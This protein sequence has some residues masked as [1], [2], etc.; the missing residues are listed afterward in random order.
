MKRLALTTASISVLLLVASTATGA[1]NARLQGAFQVTATV[2]KSDS[3]EPGTQVERTYKFKPL[4]DQGVCEKVRISRESSTG[5]FVKTVLKKTSKGTYKGKEVQKKPVCADGSKAE[6]RTGDIVAKI[7][8]QDG[9][10]A[11]KVK[12]TVKLDTKGC[13]EGT[14]T[15]AKY[16]GTR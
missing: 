13:P 16:V 8:K 5:V 11:T 14:F 4:C 1:V 12:G 10:K 15:D 7:V 2:T 3:T 6:S 9:G